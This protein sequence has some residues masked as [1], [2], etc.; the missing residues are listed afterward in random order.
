MSKT[1]ITAGT[2]EDP[3]RTGLAITEPVDKIEQIQT[4]IN[5]GIEQW[6]TAGEIIVQLID[7]EGYD[8]TTLSAEIGI[9]VS[10]LAKFEL[11][12]RKQLHPRL[13]TSDF[14][15]VRKIMTL[16]YSEQ[17]RLLEPT[18]TVDLIIDGGETLKTPVRNLTPSQV[19]QVFTK[20]SIRTPG[21]QRAYIEDKKLEQSVK[22]LPKVRMPYRILKGEV[23]FDAGCHLTAAEIA[24]L[25]L[26]LT[27]K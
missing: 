12:G 18:A 9:S 8:L 27:A 14:P 26:E 23:Y 24:K 2:P 21:E 7:D 5:R 16:P 15:A 19:H 25:Q 20:N 17:T 6:I 4:L 1:T 3:H 13:L 10:P 22:E 11:L